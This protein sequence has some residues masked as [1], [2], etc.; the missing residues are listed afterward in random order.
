MVDELFDRDYRASRGVLNATIAQAL[1]RLA[2]AI[3]SASQATHRI[4]F[5]APWTAVPRG[6]RPR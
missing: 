5:S 3:S 6:V 2:R 4:Q 1:R